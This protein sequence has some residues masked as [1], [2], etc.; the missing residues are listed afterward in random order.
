MISCNEKGFVEKAEKCE[1]RRNW[2]WNEAKKE[3]QKSNPKLRDQRFKSWA[4]M[5]KKFL[6]NWVSHE[7]WQMINA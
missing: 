5:E 4:F 1:N 7:L 2:D 3:I 6:L